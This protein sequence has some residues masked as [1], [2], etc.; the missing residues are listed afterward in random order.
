MTGNTLL[1]NIKKGV[2]R[3][4]DRFIFKDRN[5]AYN[6]A[7]VY[8]KNKLLFFDIFGQKETLT[9]NELLNGDFE[10]YLEDDKTKINNAINYVKNCLEHLC[11][12]D[13]VE[14]L[15]K[16]GYNISAGEIDNFKKRNH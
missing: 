6:E 9:S 1:K 11:P 15:H 13:E 7:F 14:I 4:G 8:L 5:S 16:L 10:Q 12:V 2:F 3:D